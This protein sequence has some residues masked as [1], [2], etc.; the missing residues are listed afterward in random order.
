MH[1]L[2]L[3]RSQDDLT[4]LAAVLCFVKTFDRNNM[5]IISRRLPLPAAY[6]YRWISPPFSVFTFR[7]VDCTCTVNIIDEVQPAATR[8][9]AKLVKTQTV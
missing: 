6:I 2:K 5:F 8:R 1:S 9:A 4:Y 3:V 7:N